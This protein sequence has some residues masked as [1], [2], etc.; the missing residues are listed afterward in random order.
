MTEI[1]PYRGLARVAAMALFMQSLDATILNTALPTIAADLHA[2]A[3]EMQMAIIAYSLAVALFIPLT[4]WAAAKFGTLTVFRSAVFIFTFGSAVC[5]AAPNLDILILARV[6]QGIG[7]AFMMPVARLAIIQSVPKHQLLNAWNLMATAGLIGPILGPI[8]GGWL[9][10]HATWHWIFLINI[11]IGI[12]GIFTSGRVMDNIK[13]GEERLDWSGFLLFALGLVGLTLGLDLMGESQR[14]LVLTYGSLILGMGLLTLYVM[15]A[16]GNER[17]ILPL[18]LFRTRTFSL[19]ILANLFIRFSASGIPFLLP[20]MFQLSF[21]YSAEMSGWL[22]APIALM[23]VIFKTVIGR[24]LNKFGYKTT[25][26]SSALLMAVGMIAMA[27]LDKQSALGWIICNLMW[28]GACMSM[29]FTAVNTLTVGDL[30]QT[31]AGAGSTLLSIVQQVGIGFGIAVSSIILNFYRQ[32]FGHEGE[33]LQQAFRYTFLTSSV[34]A[35][36]LVWTLAKLHKTD[37]DHLRGQA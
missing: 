9:V 20:L 12:L 6:I 16:K 5:A 10:I 25:L 22:L 23:S 21:G 32:L 24:I 36:A 13:G 11:P 27:Y 37:G 8:L 15:Y 7:G 14:N 30:S 1:R 29:I 4:A 3:F 26:I 33:L 2:P 34:F 28:Y 35:I 18:S 31:Q 17:A 19:G